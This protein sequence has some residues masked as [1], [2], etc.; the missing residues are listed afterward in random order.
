[1]KKDPHDT[2]TQSENRSGWLSDGGEM[3]RRIRETDWSR[4]PVGPIHLWPQ[5]LKTAVRMIL[6]SRYPMFIWWGREMTNFYNDAYAP[7]LGKRHPGALGRSAFEIWTDIWDVVGPQ[8]EAVMNRG[9][10]SWNEDLLLVMER[11]G[12]PEET[13]FTFSY[14]P[15]ANDEG[16]PGGVFCACSEETRRV[17]GARRLRTLRELAEKGAQAKTAEEACRLSAGAIANNPYDLPFALIY[18]FDGDG[19]ARLAGTAG[20]AEG[21]PAAPAELAAG[22]AA[23]DSWPLGLVVER[24]APVALSDLSSRFGDVASGPWPEAPHTAYLAPVARPSGGPLAGVLVA[25]V[26]ARRELDDDYRGFLDL[27]AGHVGTAIASARGYEEARRRAEELAR[28]DRAKTAFFS[29]VSHEFRTPLTLM[30]G[31]IED[32]LADGALPPRE[33]ERLE[34]AHRNSLRLL[35]L[36]NTLLDFS[37]IEAG[38]IDASYEAVDLSALTAE[39]ASVFRSAVERAGLR[40]VVDCPP[41]GGPSGEPAY[42]DREMWEKIVFNLL[43]NAFKFTFEG[44]IEVRLRRE[45]GAARLTVRDTGTGMPPEELPHLFERFYRVRGARG[46]SFEGSGIGLALVEQLVKLHGGSVRVES[47]VGRGSTFVVSIPLGAAH[48]PPDRVGAA[49][50]LASTGLHAEVYVEEALRW[51]ADAPPALRPPDGHAGPPEAVREASA[52]YPAR[53]AGLAAHR[54]LIAEDNADMRDYVRRLLEGPYE[55]QTVADGEAALEAARERPPD[56]ILSDVMMPKLDGLDLLRALRADER[57][58]TVPVILLSARA[59]EEARIEGLEA[60]AD[61]YVVKPFGARELIARVGAAIAM[62]RLRAEADSARERVATV[63]ESITDAFLSIGPDWRVTYVNPAG[64]RTL[65]IARDDLLGR[66]FWDIFPEGIGTAVEPAYR[67]AMEE[68]VTVRLEYYYEP[69]DRWFDVSAFPADGGGGITLVFRDISR[70]KRAEE[71]ERR[72]AAEAMAAAETNAKFRTFFEQGTYFA[73]VMT[74]DGTLLEANHLSLEA[75]GYTREQV[76]GRKFWDCPWWSPSPALVEMVREGTRVAAAG[77]VFR[78]ET[79]YF[80]TDGSERHVE[81]TLSPVT[82]EAGRVLYVAPTGVDVTERK[83]WEDERERLLESERSAR[84]QAE[85]ASRAKDEFLATVSHEL[86]T[87][88]NAMLGWSALLSSGSLDEATTARAIATI[89]RNVR[90]QAQIIDD[91]LDVSRIISGKLRLDVRLVDPGEV[92]YAVA[93]SMRPAAEAKDIRLRVLLEPGAG[94]VSAD[95]DR[96]Q[97]VVW[98]LVS[99]AVKFTPEGGVVELR[100][101]RVDTRARVSVRDTGQGIGPE[102]L[103][104]VFDRF[105]QADGSSRRKHGGLGLGLAIVR[106]L[107]EMHGGTVAVESEGEGRGAT[108]TVSLP[109]AKAAKS[110]GGEPRVPFRTTGA[111]AL[112]RMPQLE[113]LQLLVVDDEEDARDLMAEVLGRYG[114]QVVA[115]SSADEALE[116]LAS[117]RPDVL[118]SDIGMPGRDGY[119]LIRAVR[120]LGPERGGLV[121]AV[122]LTAYARMEDRLRALAAGFQVHVPKPVEPAELIQVVA[123]LGAW[124]GRGE[125]PG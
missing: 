26:S 6:G 12:Y 54:V 117:F 15:V 111:A 120:A 29:N 62:R 81:L 28:L 57:T 42:V 84:E 68:R 102:F 7:V 10:S 47:E 72:A 2:S 60:G 17:L 97:Q 90:A 37:R 92:I 116:R 55:V 25:G 14:S 82:D 99:N 94:P 75:S 76:I 124:K 40:L 5:S 50:T 78:T 58:A 86:R 89:D 16:G 51:L 32:S 44:E 77:E 48:L 56:L 88:L 4:S 8:A 49:R 109:L 11:Y 85:E 31:P 119:D 96:L 52:G 64:E 110:G 18:L 93:E 95:P 30:L 66:G 27:V 71:R 91:L 104:Y 83:L 9:Q 100:L 21:A 73:G 36:V 79:P 39:L 122:A 87:P 123:S 43:S 19:R 112:E 46:R 67:R 70:R 38:R 61:D 53:P 13:Y 107:V 114:A 118:I 101:E 59:G 3:G 65:G 34:V 35:K 74:L 98:N 22:A 106:Q 125:A 80:L 63:L 103:P 115:L 1:M 24:G 23:R 113:G 33:R 69:W 20:L 45:G 108:F 41:L 105:R 121:P